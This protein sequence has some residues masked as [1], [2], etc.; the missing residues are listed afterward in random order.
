MGGARVVQPD[1]GTIVSRTEGP[2]RCLCV[3]LSVCVKSVGVCGVNDRRVRHT[4][5][6]DAAV[7]T[8]AR[9]SGDL[10]RVQGRQPRPQPVAQRI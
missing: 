4:R 1:H 6:T 8:P 10:A 3:P 9:P 2:T 7:G 5:W